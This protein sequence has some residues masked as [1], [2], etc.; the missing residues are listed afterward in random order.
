[1]AS[2]EAIAGRDV[3]TL[4]DWIEARL[5]EAIVTPTFLAV[6]AW[7]WIAIFLVILLGLIVDLAVRAGLR[8]ASRRIA[9]RMH[10]EEDPEQLRK[11]LRPIGLAA[12]ATVWLGAM[13][14][15]ELQPT[16]DLL[17]R[18]HA[19][20]LPRL[21]VDRLGLAADRPR[22][23]LRAGARRAHLESGR[24]HPRPARHPPP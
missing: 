24:R 18:F 15:V 5:P 4:S 10:S 6:K 17:L 14:F 21:R 20:N 11:T 13:R 2:L 8:V 23:R 3:L 7:V 12:A 19:A 22:R 1:M 9:E 16:I